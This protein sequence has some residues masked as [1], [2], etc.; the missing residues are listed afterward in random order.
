MKRRKFFSTVG[1]LVAATQISP[2]IFGQDAP[3]SVMIIDEYGNKRW[4]N[5]NGELHRLN[6]PAIEC[7]NGNKHWYI[8]GKCHRTDG[9]SFESIDGIK[10]WYQHD[11]LHRTDGPAVEDA[12]GYKE[13]YLNDKQ[14]TEQQVMGA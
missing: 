8:N 4:R 1:S 11:K 3:E 9:P 13:W 7:P 10:E 5:K 2:E 14:V 6:G 12:N